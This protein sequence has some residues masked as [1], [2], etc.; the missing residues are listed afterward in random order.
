M[1]LKVLELCRSSLSRLPAIHLG[2]FKQ[3]HL[4]SKELLHV[5]WQLK[6]LLSHAHKA[7]KVLNE[8]ISK[9]TR[10]SWLIAPKGTSGG[11]LHLLSL[12]SPVSMP[13]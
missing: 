9:D 8:E 3:L 1:V 7:G 5:H 11:F 13:S 6:G 10:S 12:S 4:S 2:P